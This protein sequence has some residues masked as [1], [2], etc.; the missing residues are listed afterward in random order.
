[1]KTLSLR[2]WI[3]LVLVSVLGMSGACRS[4]D[5]VR[6]GYLMRGTIV[7][8]TAEGIV[9]CIGSKDGATPG[10]E[11]SVIKF[12]QGAAKGTFLRQKVGVVKITSVVDEHFARAAIKAGQ[13]E[14]GQLVELE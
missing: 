8:K 1:M 13:A 4:A 2:L 9:I 7:D 11:L 10:Q 5:N 14:P 6:H 3:G 12:M